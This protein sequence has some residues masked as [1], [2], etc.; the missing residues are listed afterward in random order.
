MGILSRYPLT[1]DDYWRR[2]NS[3]GSQR[4]QFSLNGQ[5]V[6][7]YNVHP[8]VPTLTAGFSTQRRG[9]EI[10][11][12]LGR[13]AQESGAVLLVGDYN[14]SD[15]SDDYR[16]VTADYTDTFREVGQGLGLSYPNFNQIDAR[17]GFVPAL[18]RLD[19]VFHTAQFAGVEAQTWP[20]TGGSDHYP[21]RV[22]L[23]LVSP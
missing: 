4:I 16:H 14:M 13:A 19:Y 9:E 11:Y 5:T 20:T 22:R 7:L 18:V 15:Q 17:L 1:A 8:P 2:P 21:L 10:D 6:T 3:L 12:L 23:A